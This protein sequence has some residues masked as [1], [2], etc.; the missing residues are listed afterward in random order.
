MFVGDVLQ[1]TNG[2]DLVQ[3]ERAV[4]AIAHAAPVLPQFINVNTRNK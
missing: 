4:R 2:P 3:H 1:L